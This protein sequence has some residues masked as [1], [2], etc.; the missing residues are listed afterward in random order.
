MFGLVPAPRFTI[1]SPGQITAV[2]PAG[3]VSTVDVQVVGPGGTSAVSTADRYAY[4]VP[5]PTP[6]T[7]L[8]SR[9]PSPGISPAVSGLGQTSSR[10]RRGNSRP[11]ISRARAP[12][13]TTFNFNLSKPATVRLVFSQQLS[14]RRVRGVCKAPNPSNARRRKCKRAVVGGTLTFAGHTG[15]NKVRFQGQLA[16]GKKLKLGNYAAVLT[17]RD[18]QGLQSVP[19]SLTFAIVG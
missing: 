3:A 16:D 4:L 1:E 12:V 10:W 17:A 6:A 15:L 14:G 9:P 7:N 2:A 18:A 8:L 19:R 11:K 13:G 5:P